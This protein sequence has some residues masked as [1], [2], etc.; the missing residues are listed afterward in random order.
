MFFL[1]CYNQLNELSFTYRFDHVLSYCVCKF[2]GSTTFHCF[3]FSP[4]SQSSRMPIVLPKFAP[5]RSPSAYM[6]YMSYFYYQG[7]F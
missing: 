3:V 7:G 2:H 6:S 1:N 4:A 5:E